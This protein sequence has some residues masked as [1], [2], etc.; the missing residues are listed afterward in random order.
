M[1]EAQLAS[2]GFAAPKHTREPSVIVHSVAR[3]INQTVINSAVT[4]NFNI[5]AWDGKDRL[6]VSLDLLKAAFRKSELLQEYCALPEK[7]RLEPEF[8]NQYVLEALMA[9]IRQAHRSPDSR[10]IRPNPCR[11]D[12]VQVLVQ[13]GGERWEILTL[14]EATRLLFR[15]AASRIVSLASTKEAL[16][17]LSSAEQTASLLMPQEYRRSPDRYEREGKSRLA[18]HLLCLSALTHKETKGAAAREPDAPDLPSRRPVGSART[19]PLPCA[20]T[21]PET[22]PTTKPI[23][24][25][26]S[27]A[28]PLPPFSPEVAARLL[29]AHPP[30]LSCSGEAPLAELARLEAVSGQEAG[31]IV[32]HLL[33]AKDM[34]LLS[35]KEQSWVSALVRAHDS[36]SAF[37]AEPL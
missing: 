28:P 9:V 1:L 22:R 2:F 36:N 10:N 5:H 19:D 6:V 18:A 33:D 31:R 32:N 25:G 37:H 7:N 8:I 14:A 21:L 29:R 17:H 30:A 16:H 15:D 35:E 3:T 13:E 20:E 34:G 23:S 27:A 24:A 4:N 12:Q 26:L 11:A